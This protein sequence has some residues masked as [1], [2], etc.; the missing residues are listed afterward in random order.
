MTRVDQIKEVRQLRFVQGLPIREISRRMNMPRNTV[1][2]ILRSEATKFT[3]TRTKPHQPIT[4]K[5]VMIDVD[6]AELYEVETK[7]L[8]QAV[9][10]N[11]NRF[12][13]DF[14]FRLTKQEKDELVTNCDRFESLKHSTVNPHVFTEQGVAMLSSVLRSERAVQVNIEIM[15]AFVRYREMLVSVKELARKVESLEKKY[16]SQFAIVFKAIRQ[17][18]APSPNDKKQIGFKP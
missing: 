17:L 13:A 8:N 2:K 4:G 7:K 10:R 3:Y 14:M 6:L 16:D 12:P 15:R 18:M 9:K 5:Q 1:R 11:V